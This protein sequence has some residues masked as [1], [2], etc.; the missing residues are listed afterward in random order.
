MIG[1]MKQ[2]FVAAYDNSQ[3]IAILGSQ[4]NEA[5]DLFPLRL[6]S[7]MGDDACQVCQPLD[8]DAGFVCMKEYFH[9]ASIT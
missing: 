8:L 9:A 3:G 2:S 4:E 1:K 7:R 6:F 5:E